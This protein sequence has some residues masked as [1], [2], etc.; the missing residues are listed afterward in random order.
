MTIREFIRA[1]YQSWGVSWSEA[2]LILPDAS[3]N[4]EEDITSANL[5]R[6]ERALVQRLPEL[7]LMPTSVSE[8]GVSI[9]RASR[10]AI[11]A[12]YSY[13]CR[14]LGLSDELTEE[15]TIEFL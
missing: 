7:L 6:V 9:S 12:Y 4:V 5:R 8:L 15:N 3:I 2:Y 14:E 11:E 10:D 13:K 1:K